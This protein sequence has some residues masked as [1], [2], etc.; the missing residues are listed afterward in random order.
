MI[1]ISVIL[2]AIGIITLF[3]SFSNNK[4]EEGML[5]LLV[6]TGLGLITSSSPDLWSNILAMVA[7]VKNQP[8][9]A[10]N[11]IEFNYYTFFVGIAILVVSL[12]IYIKEK[13]KMNI[14]NI[15]GYKRYKIE[16]YLI[17]KKSEYSYKEN[18]INFIDIYNKIFKKNLDEESCECILNQIEENVKAFRNQSE[19][20]KNGYTGIAPIP[21]IVYAGTFL[22]RFGIDKY[23]EYNKNNMAYYE[24]HSNK[25]ETYPSLKLKTNI[26][27]LDTSKKE[28]T[29]VISLTQKI[30][31]EDIKQFSN[32]SNIIKLEVEKCKDNVIV[33]KNQLYNYVEIVFKN[34]VDIS[35]KLGNISK[36]NLIMAAQSCFALEVGKRC[37]DDTRLPQIISYQYENQNEIKYPWGIVINGK[38]KK[39]LVKEI[40]DV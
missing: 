15:N 30:K 10:N 35:D 23:Y 13:R 28:V 11:S 32:N 5:K 22:D 8:I 26:D 17:N 7:L 18:E 33:N 6:T 37:I 38:N 36:I 27:S 12:I 21:F 14:L 24:L 34:I 40:K 25:K 1:Y 29:L 3:K 4:N 2:F 39:K 9:I 31:N 16:N 19:E 20:M